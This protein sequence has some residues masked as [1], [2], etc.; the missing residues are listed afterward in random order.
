MSCQLSVYPVSYTWLCATLVTELVAGSHN[1]VHVTS[2]IYIVN[3][4]CK[5]GVTFWEPPFFDP[6]HAPVWPTLV[7][8]EPQIWMLR[9]STAN[10][11]W[12]LPYIIM[13][14]AN[15]RPPKT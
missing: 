9:Y 8:R 10:S 1:N 15:A 12:N 14:A 4:M 5:A 7:V 6:V 2:R 3:N 11:R 13:V